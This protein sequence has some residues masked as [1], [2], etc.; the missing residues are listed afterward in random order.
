M[1]LVSI[2]DVRNSSGATTDLIEDAKIT[3]MITK[4]QAQALSTYKVFITPTKFID[5]LDGNNKNKIKVDRPY[6][7]K[8]LELK[9][10]NDVIDLDNVTIEPISSIITVDN[11][12]S[13]YYFYNYQNSVRVKYLSA[14]MEKTTTITETTADVEA[15]STVAIAVDDETSF[16]VDDWVVIE[17]NDGKLEAAQVTA[18]GTDEITVDLLVQD[19]EEESLIT[20]LQTHELLTQ[21]IIYD[22]NTNVANYIVGNTSNLATSWSQGSESATV[23]VAYT[24][25]RESAAN[26]AKKRDEF[27][28]KIWNK[29]NPIS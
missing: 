15:G 26:F 2:D 10:R 23:G 7:W 24:H 28:G 29:L 17:G 22:V 13:P 3:D 18:T 19:H 21:F 11:T 20:K 16:A 6:I 25:W 27:K 5:I 4:S 14:F 12:Q 1:S 8:I 9:T